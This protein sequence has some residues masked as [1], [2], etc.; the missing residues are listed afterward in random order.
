MNVTLPKHNEPN[1]R[2]FSLSKL[3]RLG[4]KGSKNWNHI[5]PPSFILHISN[6]FSTDKPNKKKLEQLLQGYD[7]Y[8]I[9]HFKTDQIAY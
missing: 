5:C 6:I 1:A 9:L 2:D 8:V 7:K 4:V 3:Q